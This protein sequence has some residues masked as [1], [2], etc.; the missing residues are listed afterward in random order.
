MSSAMLS[1]RQKRNAGPT[2]A[3]KGMTSCLRGGAALRPS[4]K[5][6]QC[7]Q[8]KGYVIIAV[9]HRTAIAEQAKQSS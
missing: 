8:H 9:V 4:S 6:T 5:Q 2:I 3:S 1:S 7:G